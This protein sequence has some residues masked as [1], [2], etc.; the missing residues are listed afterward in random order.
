MGMK[1]HLHFLRLSVTIRTLEVEMK[2]ITLVLLC[3]AIVAPLFAQNISQKNS[4]EYYYVNVS[5]EKVYPTG[6]GYVIQY[7]K[8]MNETATIGIPNEWFT[9]A[10]GKAELITLPPGKNWPTLTIFYK[11]GEF[12]HIRLY[13]HHYKGHR[14]WG[15]APVGADVSRYFKDQDSIKIEF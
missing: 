6:P 3:G 7:R 9:D 2:K 8:G 12:S 14:T 4:S 13:V 15:N 10:G 5:L 1:L 11:N